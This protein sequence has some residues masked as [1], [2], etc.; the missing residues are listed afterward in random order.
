ML[1]YILS[2]LCLLLHTQ[3]AT[4][5]PIHPITR[6]TCQSTGHCPPGTLI[7]SRT[8]NHKNTTHP[9]LQSAINSLPN[10]NTPQTI[11][12]LAGSYIEQVNITRPGPLT[13]LGETSNPRDAS[14]NRVRIT[15]AAANSDSTGAVD[16]VF[17]SVLVVA[18]TLEAS[19]TGSGE[20]GYPVPAD[21]PFG[22]TDFRVYNVDFEN[23][24]AEYSDGPA[25]ALSLSRANGGFY[26]CGFY[27]YQDT[28]RF[29]FFL[30]VLLVLLLRL[31][32]V[33][34][35]EC[36]ILTPT[37]TPTGLHRQTRQRL[38]LPK[39]PSRPNR[40]P[41]RLRHSLDSIQR[42]PAARLRRRHN[43]LE[44]HE[45]HN[46]EQVRRVHSRLERARRECLR[47]D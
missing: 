39:H 36:T 37:L 44:G 18:P 40:L 8:P 1:P 27:S 46:P 26:Y 12:L 11:L 14:R 45:H 22:N 30:T 33:I 16:N 42:A 32:F 47:S 34:R 24:W 29:S 9:T 35:W 13:L 3:G 43:R 20:T 7:V 21:T 5:T 6:Q 31:L 25:H 4:T 23:T 38:L 17:S 10:D 28:V 2:L 41:L 15:W 19:L